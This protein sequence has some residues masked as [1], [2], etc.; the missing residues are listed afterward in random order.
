MIPNSVKGRRY[1]TAFV[2]SNIQPNSS[3]ECAFRQWEF[4][5]LQKIN[6]PHM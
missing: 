3:V 2:V 1:S 5:S 6:L 4:D